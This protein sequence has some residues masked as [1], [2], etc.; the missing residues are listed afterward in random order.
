VKYERRASRKRIPCYFVKS[1]GART[2]HR[3]D[4]AAF[5]FVLKRRGCEMG[6]TEVG[7]VR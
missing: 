5:S 7:E 6:Y 2:E 1:R 4:T 3:K